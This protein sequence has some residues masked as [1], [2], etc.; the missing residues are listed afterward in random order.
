MSVSTYAQGQGSLSEE[1][2]WIPILT[3]KYPKRDR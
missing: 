2:E 3:P 1:L